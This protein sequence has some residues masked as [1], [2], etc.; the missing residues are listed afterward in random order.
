[1]QKIWKKI[2]DNQVAR[3]LGALAKK[4]SGQTNQEKAGQAPGF[5]EFSAFFHRSSF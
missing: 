3:R 2:V 5:I 1:M 4:N